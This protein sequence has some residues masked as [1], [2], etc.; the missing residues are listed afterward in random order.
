MENNSKFQ[1]VGVAL[2]TPFAENGGI[3]F[4]ALAHVIEY[5]IKGGVDYIVALGTTSEAPTMT[6]DERVAVAKFVKE[7]VGGRIPLVIGVGGN[8][9]RDVEQALRSGITE[10]YDAVLS[11]SPYYNKPNQEGL[12]RHFK[13]L[14][15]VS[16]LPILLYNVPG[17]TGVNIQP[18]T[19]ARLAADCP[20]I[21]GIKE[22]SGNVAQMR[23]V[24]ERTPKEFLLI[25][26]DDALTVDAMRLGGVGVISGLAQL[27]PTQTAAFVRA[28]AEGRFD[29]A[30][31]LFAPLAQMTAQ[32]FEEGNPVGIKTAMAIK[33]LCGATMRLPLVEGSAAL[34]EKM[35]RT[36]AEYENRR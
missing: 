29:E 1:G 33:G 17:R 25:S 26:G 2:I 9:T 8:C 24:R 36:I 22:A 18:A 35:E 3:D 6:A 31:A 5:I 7:R 19:V 27:Y 23:E 11:V 4:G 15:E 20:N 32:L 14:A 13:A 21:I 12:Y 30:D 28:A 34:R 16:P 10:G